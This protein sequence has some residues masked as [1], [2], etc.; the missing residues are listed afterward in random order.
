MDV[1]HAG[2]RRRPGRPHPPSW[3]RRAVLLAAVLGILLCVLLV[4]RL[5]GGLLFTPAERVLIVG[6][7]AAGL[8]AAAALSGYA[9]V[10]VLEAQERLG[11]RVHTNHSLGVPVELGAAW[12][13]RAEGNVVSQLAREYGCKTVVSESKRLVVY[14]ESGAQ[15]GASTVTKVYRQLMHTIMPEVLRQRSALRSDGRDDVS[16]ATLV[17]RVAAVSGLV[18]AKRCVLDFL[19]FRDIVQVHCD[20][21]PKDMHTPNASAR[22]L[23][24][25]W[26]C[27]VGPYG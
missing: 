6:G 9:T 22:S 26:F 7:G 24:T 27:P 8:A 21:Q 20:H 10:L 16:L 11:G 5:P 2:G 17:S 3:R 15:V 18:G 14:G 25:G 1:M 4:A 12:I 23:S 19:L 13:H